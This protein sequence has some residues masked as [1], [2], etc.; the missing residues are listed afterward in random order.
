MGASVT[1]TTRSSTTSGEPK[2]PRSPFPRNK[3]G[4]RGCYVGGCRCDPCRE[5][6]R[7]YQKRHAKNL[8]KGI[9]NPLVPADVTR[10]HLKKLKREGVGTRLISDLTG[11]SR[12][13]LMDILSGEKL[14]CRADTQRRVLGVKPSAKNLTD[15]L[16]VPA[17]PTWAL[18]DELI[19]KGF[20]KTEL[21]RRLG[22]KSKV[23]ALQIKRDYVTNLNRQRVENLHAKCLAELATPAEPPPPPDPKLPDIDWKP[24]WLKKDRT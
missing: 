17:G 23:P 9:R 5:A 4:T 20:T 22:S 10:R 12:T 1:K 16:L 24:D 8:R 14:K 11:C 21:A 6:N 13:V 2:Q 18:L 15:A 7:A 19:A 3:H